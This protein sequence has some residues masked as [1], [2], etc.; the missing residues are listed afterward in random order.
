[1]PE[2]WKA[3]AMVILKATAQNLKGHARKLLLEQLLARRQEAIRAQQWHLL[4]QATAALLML[5]TR[6]QANDIV[7]LEKSAIMLIER[8][9]VLFAAIRG[10]TVIPSADSEVV[11]N[12]SV[13]VAQRR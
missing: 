13:L 11:R 9:I 3:R 12:H 4:T 6:Q 5:P 10:E 7:F 8:A 1:M 2:D